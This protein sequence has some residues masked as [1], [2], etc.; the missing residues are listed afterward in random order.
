MTVLK[1]KS[2]LLNVAIKEDV[3]DLKCSTAAGCVLEIPL[4]TSWLYCCPEMGELESALAP[5]T[6]IDHL[7]NLILLRCD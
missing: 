4:L 1:E 5:S 3:L 6:I 2:L 7:G